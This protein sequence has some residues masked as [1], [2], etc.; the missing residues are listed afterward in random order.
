[1]ALPPGLDLST[2]AHVSEGFSAGSIA[3]AVTKTMTQRRVQRMSKRQLLCGE[4]LSGLAQ[5]TQVRVQCVY[6]CS[7]KLVLLL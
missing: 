5:E 7:S 2:L 3:A 4:F 6:A 1:M